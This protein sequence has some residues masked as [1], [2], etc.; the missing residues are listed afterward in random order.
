MRILIFLTAFL[1]VPYI[2]PGQAVS[3]T[4]KYKKHHFLKQ[5]GLPVGLL[6]GSLILQTGH[7]KQD[8]QDLFPD[9][10]NKIADWL[11][12]GPEVEMYAF[13]LAGIKHSNTVFNQTK[14]LLISHLVTAGI[15]QALKVTTHV[16]RP[17]GGKHSFPSGHTS[18]AFVGATV[19]Y[20]EFKESQPLLA[21]SGFA[22][23]TATGILRITND[24]HWLPD[25]MA[26]AAIGILV[27][28]LVYQIKPFKNF[29]PFSQNCGINFIT[30]KNM[31]QICL[32]FSF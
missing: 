20:H 27:T 24:A 3:D 2:L 4:S 29:Q 22:L 17:Y 28:N 30:E 13:D 9:T 8:I 11:K 21:C 23:A 31:N 14:Y 1:I 16:T 12:N 25:V 7:I 15:V 18:Y 19:L 26:G 32:H 6:A 5:Y 10:D